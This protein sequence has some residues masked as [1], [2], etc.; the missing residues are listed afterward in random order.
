MTEAEYRTLVVESG[1]L[2][3]EFIEQAGNPSLIESVALEFFKHPFREEHYPT[4]AEETRR[5]L[6]QLHELDGTT[7]FAKK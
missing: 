3:V 7:G 6:I 4:L 2:S 5:A 1:L